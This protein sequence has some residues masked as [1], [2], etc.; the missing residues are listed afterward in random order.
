M[1]PST[2]AEVMTAVIIIAKKLTLFMRNRPISSSVEASRA[3]EALV[4]G[5]PKPLP[6]KLA[7]L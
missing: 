4:E 5:S 1:E 2:V 6:S 3:T 7:K